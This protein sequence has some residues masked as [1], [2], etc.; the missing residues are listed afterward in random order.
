MVAFTLLNLQS[1]ETVERTYD[2]GKR[3]SK[4][5]MRLTRMTGRKYQVRKIDE[6]EGDPEWRAREQSRFESG[7]YIKLIDRIKEISP[8]DHFAHIA[9]KSPELVAYTKDELR[10]RTD[11]QSLI[12]VRAYI[13]LC[14]QHPEIQT[15]MARWAR[16][17]GY[18]NAD[19]YCA[20][21]YSAASREEMAQKQMDY[22][23]SFCNPIKF[24]GPLPENFTDEDVRRIG[25]EI[26]RVYTV[27]DESV[28]ALSAS[29]MRSSA[30]EYAGR[31]DGER[32]HP[33]RAY[34]SPDLAIAYMTNRSGQ[35]VARALCWPEK[36]IYSRVYASSDAI[37]V[38]LKALGYKRSGYYGYE[39]GVPTFKGARMR[40]IENDRGGFIVPYLDDQNKYVD[41]AGDWLTMYGDEIDCETT[42]GVADGTREDDAY[43]CEHC[44]DECS[45]TTTVYLNSARSRSAEWCE[46]CAG[47]EA[48]YCHGRNEYFCEYVD[49]S[50]V[51]DQ[52][53]TD[54]Y[55]EN[56]ANWCDYYDHWTFDRIFR[57]VVDEDGDTQSW[58]EGAC[59]KHAV[60]CGDEWYSQDL[61]VVDVVV[62]RYCELISR[63]WR[64]DY[65]Y[66]VSTKVEYF[67]R[68]AMYPQ[69]VIDNGEVDVY[70]GV[71]GK[72][73]LRD[74]IDNY[75]VDRPRVAED[76]PVIQSWYDTHY[77]ARTGPDMEP[78]EFGESIVSG[79]GLPELGF[80][81][82]QCIGRWVHRLVIL[83]W[84]H[85][86][87]VAK[88]P[89]SA[90]EQ[91]L[92]AL[93]F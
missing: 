87:F 58:S 34:V 43:S 63:E 42:S 72:Y 8:D 27:Y 21:Y 61:G 89:Q 76:A 19:E 79:V 10:G 35:T 45:E 65:D 59:E 26:E 33:T 2:D 64:G 31:V 60:R 54:R 88:L 7:E 18:A 41:D 23:F 74:Y 52:I 36:K 24:A 70:L 25:D 15:K 80:D 37:H 40:R 50:V 57:V 78:D 30:R 62:E 28:N 39:A 44:G 47:S 77:V 16:I 1:N 81:Y 85:Q 14:L 32:V 46:Y 82:D 48:F 69:S 12:H 29:C 22:A 11:K 17:A 4:I 83:S 20:N 86:H 55:L 75:P 68:T 38:A 67:D 90:D 93:E 92:A 13:D 49:H 73:Y 6:S 84:Y 66:F 51:D 9:K 91:L 56:N 3:A 5:A 53:Y 71:D